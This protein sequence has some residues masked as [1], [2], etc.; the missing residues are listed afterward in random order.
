MNL[1]RQ[2]QGGR[3][4]RVKADC[5]AQQGGQ[6]SG[7]L[8][9]YPLR[10]GETGKFGD[11]RDQTRELNS[12]HGRDYDILEEPLQQV[13]PSHTAEVDYNRSISDDDHLGN[14]A[15]RLPRSSAS[16]CSV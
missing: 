9:T 10:Q 12:H 7:R 3:F 15:F 5:R 11:I 8:L 1:N 2:R 4:P 6:G 14:T 16:I 13:S